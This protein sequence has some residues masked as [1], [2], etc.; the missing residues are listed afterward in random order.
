MTQTI[1][2]QPAAHQADISTLPDQ[3]FARVQL[4][5]RVTGLGQSTLWQ[6]AKEG[7]FPST[8]K[9]SPRATVFRVEEVR[10]WMKDPQA[11]QAANKG[12]GL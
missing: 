8:V 4:V 7:R 6:W 10:E 1:G 2:Q 3:G 11:W 5:S 9:L 12:A